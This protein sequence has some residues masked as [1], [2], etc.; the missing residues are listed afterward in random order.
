MRSSRIDF[1][2]GVAICSVLLLHFSLSYHLT[3]SPLALFLKPAWIAAAVD[4]GNYGVTMFF[5]ISG[6]LISS[7]NL[8]R[9]GHLRAVNLR[10]FYTFRFARIIP[11]LLLALAIIVPLGVLGVPS[12]SNAAGGHMLPARFFVIATLSVLTFWHNVLMQQV[13]YFNYCLNIYW[14]LSVEEVFYLTFPLACRLLRHNG[15]IVGLCCAFILGAPVYRAWHPDE[16]YYECGYLACFDAIATGCLVAILNQK[17]AL[18]AGVLRALRL[19]ASVVLTA[20]YCAGID[21]HEVFGFSILALST[22]VLLIRAYEAPAEKTRTLPVRGVCWMGRHSYEL[23]LFHGIVLAGLRNVIPKG[24]MPWAWKLPLFLAFVGVAA[25][26]AALVSRY[27]AEPMNALLRR[28]AR[29]P[30]RA[31]YG[32]RGL[33]KVRLS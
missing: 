1:L 12:F 25:L 15:L 21:G 14:S 6:F 2:R 24:T 13:G 31:Y 28:V 18:G 23:Y 26:I 22:G 29:P 4:N 19:V 17:V 33:G 11:P 5:V 3:D 20:T 9:Y 32:E 7:N 8:I 16:L 27:Y 30:A 10:Q